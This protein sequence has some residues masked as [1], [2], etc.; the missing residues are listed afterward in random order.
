MTVQTEIKHSFDFEGVQ[1]RVFHCNKG[2]GIPR[3]EHYY[4][5]ATMVH[6]GS[7]RVTKE[8]VDVVLTKDSNPVILKENEWHELE[9]LE[10]GTVFMNVMTLGKY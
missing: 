6:A 9:A 4:Q 3:H 8:N 7:V 2:E 10:D 1:F 5:H